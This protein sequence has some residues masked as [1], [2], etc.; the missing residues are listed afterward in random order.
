MVALS[1]FNTSPAQIHRITKQNW[2]HFF[3]AVKAAVFKTENIFFRKFNAQKLVS[4]F[5]SL[6]GLSH[7]R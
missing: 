1:G 6:S 7:R 2:L 3:F 4:A 5:V